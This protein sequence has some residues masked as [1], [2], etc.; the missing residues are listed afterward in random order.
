[1]VAGDNSKPTNQ[2]TN[3]KLEEGFEGSILAQSL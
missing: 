1:M 3:Q 2:P